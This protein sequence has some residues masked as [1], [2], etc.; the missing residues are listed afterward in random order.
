MPQ[1]RDKPPLSTDH[2]ENMPPP[3][4]PP[5]RA[6]GGFWV[7][8][9]IVFLTILLTVVMVA[10]F[11]RTGGY[12]EELFI[13]QDPAIDEARTNMQAFSLAI[14]LYQSDHASYPAH[15]TTPTLS[16]NADL[17]AA[18]P[19]AG[20]PWDLP[21]FR[22]RG[23]T[24][25]ATLTTPAS[26]IPL[27]YPDPHSIVFDRTFNYYAGEDGW[28]LWG[29]GPDQDY[30]IDMDLLGE[31]GPINGNEEELQRMAYDPTNGVTSSG[32][33]VQWR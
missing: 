12:L 30:D 11:S 33:L 27:Y 29:A 23:D 1:R 25:L 6:L 31:G 22:N 26:Y 24:S 8:A 21:T 17:A 13:E 5:R 10:M 20:N 16:V 2:P 7:V 15:T 9:A 19:E 28:I 32:D 18:N 3:P 14:E 4:P